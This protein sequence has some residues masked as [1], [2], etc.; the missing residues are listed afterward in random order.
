MGRRSALTTGQPRRPIRRH[1]SGPA[2]PLGLLRLARGS[3]EPTEAARRRNHASHRR[4]TEQPPAH[5]RPR[6]YGQSLPLSASGVI[7][8]STTHCRW[9]PR[10]NG[11]LGQGHHA[12][13]RRSTLR[14]SCLHPPARTRL[15]PSAGLTGCRPLSTSSTYATQATSK[16]ARTPQHRPRCPHR[17]TRRE[18]DTDRRRS[19]PDRASA[20]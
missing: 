6:R 20:K 5:D 3:C 17:I 8:R 13:L 9:C 7:P 11:R 10:N 2:L 16:T 14:S 12:H 19:E 18:H 15:V 1:S 4:T